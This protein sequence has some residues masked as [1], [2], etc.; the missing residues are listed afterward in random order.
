MKKL[1][2][3][4]NAHIDPVWQW[5]W[6]EGISAAIATFK[7]ACDLADQFDYVFCH[8][9]SLLY[10][11]VE[12]NCPE[13][14]ERIKSLVKKGK[15]KITGGWY[16]QPDCL[17][18]S[19]ESF[20]RQTKVGH[21]YFEEKFGVIPEIAV[22]YDSFGHSIGL[23]QILK[24]TGYKGYV[25]FRPLKW[26]KNAHY[27]EGK[28]YNWVSPSGDS[29]LFSNSKNYGSVLGKAA[30]LITDRAK[31]AEDVDFVL[32][33][34][35]NHGGGPSRKDLKDIEN[36]KIDGF[37]IFH[38]T[39]EDLFND[40]IKISNDIDYSLVTCMAGCYSSMARVKQA[41]RQAENVLYTTEKMLSVAS[42]SG[43]NPDLKDLYEAQ[44]ALLLSE[45]HDTL[46]GSCIEDGEA[47][48]LEL[49][50]Y[51]KKI[52]RDYRTNAFMYLTAGEPV[53]QEGEFP[54][55]VF[56]PM[57]YEITEPIEAEFI[58]PDQNW[59]YDLRYAPVVYYNG[60]E[61]PCQE[62]KEDSN[63]NLDWRKRIVFNGTLKPLGVTRFSVFVKEEK[64]YD[65]YSVPAV[66]GDIKEFIKGSLLDSPVAL[67]MYDDTADPWGMSEDE[68]RCMG[69]NPVEFR[70]MTEQECKDFIVSNED[71]YP[72]HV[73]EDG[74]ILT[75]V[76]GFYTKNK[77]D[78]VIEY[79]RYK[80][81]SYV[82]L[83]VTVEF[84]EKNK[85]VK[86]KI[87]APKGVMIGDGPFVVE[88]KPLDSELSFQKWLGVRKED[89]QVFAVINDGVYSGIIKD[90]YIYLTLL[91]GAGY[92][93]HPLPIDEYGL[94]PGRR[95]LYP[96]D[97][98]LPRIDNGR[99]TYR[100]R[101]MT[102]TVEEVTTMSEL[103]N[104]KPYA[105]NVFPIGV[106]ERKTQIYT[107]K[108]VVMP[109][110]KIGE[111][112]GYV[113]RFF[114]PELK[115]KTFTLTIEGNSQQITMSKMEVISVQYLDKKFTVL[116][117][118]LIV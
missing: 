11:A 4:C 33:G 101:I 43:Y 2:L 39:L 74:E 115:D 41:H 88:E 15:W 38:S 55:Y 53:A 36:L 85:L 23:V 62:I 46:P 113:L 67:E 107:D 56:N 95:K 104:Q 34:V 47:N 61:I 91:R 13:L 93:M 24:K 21:K 19:G 7:S 1:H 92:C 100:L 80:D 97:R 31:E 77:T 42:L 117:D 71:I 12:K 65:R 10:E 105:I 110:M 59:R 17:M 66:K 44:K 26:S 103:F 76:E 28:F 49:L 5:T 54:I 14:F 48:A 25:A 89:G 86:L 109:T 70:L 111:D 29:I 20:V 90:G 57:P 83:K 9:E 82:D 3:I 96:T 84:S 60:K 106:G 45:F 40:D 30:E 58:L 69:K 6:D 50:N 114:N 94:I 8:N 118:K 32:W 72:E 99:Y 52:C 51:C 112:G 116:H 98:Y 102:G 16:L 63:M 37:N 27:P 75:S 108:P 79:R 68:Q 22:N 18:P 64:G 78:A 73:I 35:G 81:K 87:P